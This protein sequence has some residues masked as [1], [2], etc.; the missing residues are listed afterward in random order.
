MAKKNLCGAYT[1]IWAFYLSC[2][3]IDFIIME[4]ERLLFC[5][6]RY[7]HYYDSVNNKSSV[8]LGLSTFI[9]GGLIVG[10]FAIKDFVVCTP[11]IYLLMIAL[12]LLGIVIMIV[13]ILAATPFVSKG[14]DSLH[15]F[16]SISCQT[17][18]EF[19][20]Q[21]FENISTEDELKDLRLQ[22]HQLACGL[23]SKFSKLKIAGIMFTIQFV[24]F[25]PLLML[26]IHNLK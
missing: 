18:D 6:G 13:V 3:K 11:W 14:T 1:S 16:G 19:S 24:L 26:I 15:Y 22:V 23:S 20:I 2:V 9:V 10:F 4:K 8:F 21:S 12:I 17:H 25:I 5:I 7:D